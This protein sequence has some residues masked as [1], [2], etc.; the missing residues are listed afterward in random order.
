MR[1]QQAN[2][3]FQRMDN[4]EYINAYGINFQSKSGSLLLVSENVHLS[5]YYFHFIDTSLDF[6]N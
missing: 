5:S 4:L 6:E 1:K 3:G 2:R